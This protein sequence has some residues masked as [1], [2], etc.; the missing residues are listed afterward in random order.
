MWFVS[1]V[2]IVGTLISLLV[3]GWGAYLEGSR[4]ETKVVSPIAGPVPLP[5][6]KPKSVAQESVEIEALREPRAPKQRKTK[7]RRDL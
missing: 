6:P 3:F 2:L 4:P 7:V 1:F 5:M